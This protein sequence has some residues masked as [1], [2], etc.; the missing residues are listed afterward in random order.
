MKLLITSMATTAG[1]LNPE[2]SM[3]AEREALHLPPKTYV[4][5]TEENLDMHQSNGQHTPELYAGQGEDE[6]PR[7]PVRGMHKNTS[8]VRLNG[9]A[10]G[11]KI[12][13]VVVE[14]YQDK[15]GERLV[16]LRGD[17][18]Q[19]R[20]TNSELVSGKKA[21]ERWAQSP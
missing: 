7:T 2:P 9:G 12:S 15:D 4:D 8:S 14:R 1:P 5:A 11:K 19:P 13:E 3:P 16:S 18:A 21:G 10:K 20:R 17:R 6:A